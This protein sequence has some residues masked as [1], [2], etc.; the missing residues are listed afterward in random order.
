MNVVFVNNTPYCQKS[1]D[2]D[3]ES[4]EKHLFIR[5]NHGKKP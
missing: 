3:F 2:R 4:S 1:L 5:Y